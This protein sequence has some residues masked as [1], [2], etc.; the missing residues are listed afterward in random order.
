M[1]ESA[2]PGGFRHNGRWWWGATAVPW[3]V[4][5]SGEERFSVAP[6]PWAGGRRAI[7]QVSAPGIGKPMFGKPHCNRQREA[8]AANKCDLCGLT[9]RNTTRVSLSHARPVGHGANGLAILQVEPLLHRGCA[10]ESMRFCP[11]LRR[12]IDAGT[13]VIRQV[14]GCRVQFAVMSPEY[15]S[16]YV[17]GYKAQ[18]TD[19]I[20][21]AA[22]VEL[23]KWIDRDMR[24][25]AMEAK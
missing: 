24:W 7:C 15:V 12:D 21:G 3:T 17:Q 16:H 25:L 19:R 5:W 11:S 18:P 9:L 10:L 22:K 2:L 14:T 6:C 1:G 8:I 4:G 20:V 23:L 13:L